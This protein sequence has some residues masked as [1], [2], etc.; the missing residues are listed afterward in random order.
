MLMVK[1]EVVIVETMNSRIHA[2][3][4]KKKRLG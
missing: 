4:K 1:I 2:Q 3:S